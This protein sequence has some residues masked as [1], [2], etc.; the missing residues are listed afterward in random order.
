M[1]CCFKREHEPTRS[2]HSNNPHTHTHNRHK[3]KSQSSRHFCSCRNVTERDAGWNHSTHCTSFLC[4]RERKSL[5]QSRARDHQRRPSGSCAAQIVT[6]AKRRLLMQQIAH[7]GRERGKELAW[8]RIMNKTRQRKSL[9]K[10]DPRTAATLP[11]CCC[12]SIQL[13]IGEQQRIVCIWSV[14]NHSKN[15]HDLLQNHNL[16]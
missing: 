14:C 3:A 16:T 2:T 6:A 5:A 10:D 11:A 8:K 1:N 9:T 15:G 12:I 7:K 4:A 13:E